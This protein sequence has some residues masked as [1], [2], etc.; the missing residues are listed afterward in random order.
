MSWQTHH[1]Q[2]QRLSLPSQM[3]QGSLTAALP[4][5]NSRE[6]PLFFFGPSVR[7]IELERILSRL[8]ELRRSFALEHLA[9]LEA[10]GRRCAA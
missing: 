8:L 4:T 9:K 2:S 7:A 6:R 1:S 10:L 3:V 5:A